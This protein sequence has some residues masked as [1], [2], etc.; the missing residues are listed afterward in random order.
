MTTF[1]DENSALGSLGNT[2]N[3]LIADVIIPFSVG[4]MLATITYLI[5]RDTGAHSIC[6]PSGLVAGTVVMSLCF[7]SEKERQMLLES[8]EAFVSQQDPTLVKAGG[9]LWLKLQCLFLVS[10]VPAFLGL[11]FFGDPV[12]QLYLE[13]KGAYSL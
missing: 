9:T 2:N 12:F 5:C 6:I 4:V 8:D 3:P 11:V 10:A 13:V 1:T 7:M